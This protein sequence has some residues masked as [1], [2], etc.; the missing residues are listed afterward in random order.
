MFVLF[1]FQRFKVFIK[2]LLRF[3]DLQALADG[4]VEFWLFVAIGR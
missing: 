3:W 4:K 1:L 2:F